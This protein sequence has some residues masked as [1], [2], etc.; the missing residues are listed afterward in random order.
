MTTDL[1]LIQHVQAD[2]DW[3]FTNILG[4]EHMWDK[5]REIL[6]AV[7][8]KPRVAV[9]G[10]NGTG[11]D[12]TSARIM[13]WWM[14]THKPAKV[15]VVGPSHRQVSDIVFSEA[16]LAFNQA[17]Y[18]LDGTFL[19]TSAWNIGDEYYARGFATTDPYNALGFH[20]PHLLVIITEA[21]NISQAHIDSVKR[22]LP[23]C[24]LMTG[25]PFCEAGEFYDAFNAGEDNWI[26]IRIS[27]FDTPNLIEGRTVI[28]GMASVA[29]VAQMA[30][31][32]G[33]DDP[34]Y[35]GSALGQFSDSL[36]HTIVARSEIMAAVKRDL[37]PDDDDTVT[38]SC[39]VARFG[40]DRT[41][42]YRRQG[43]QCRKVWDVQGHDTQDVAGNLGLLA[44]AEGACDDHEGE[45]RSDCDDCLPWQVEI[46]VDDTGV[47]GGV[48]DRLN[49]EAARI[50]G[51]DC[52]II[53]FN[54][55][56]KADDE[57]HYVNAIAEAWLDL[58]KAFKA[59]MVDLDDNPQVIAQLAARRKRIQG[60]RRLRLESKD[61]YKK[62]IKRSP[63]DADAL[64]MA[65]SP[66][67]GSP[68]L[69]FFDL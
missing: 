1:E 7:R 4:V 19:Q 57:G 24:I 53:P 35:I 13:L 2:P 12:W 22:L 37:P 14:S 28:P 40:S 32:W 17:K 49:E 60:D 5:P 47:G 9:C 68:S 58:A 23:T 25:N 10:A 45:W 65:Y 38:L 42:V 31:D 51:G 18:P 61:E 27:A 26:T 8:D 44:N 50:R 55:G 21:H 30:K 36:E 63:D 39:D 64:A 56:E 59:D 43:H 66:L 3:F 11:K 62:R 48:T 69:R 29:S 46:I 6:A 16:R 15:I 33:D 54:G 41:V 20:S 34:L 52:P 67:C